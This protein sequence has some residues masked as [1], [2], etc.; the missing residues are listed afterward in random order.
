MP[1]RL[2]NDAYSAWRLCPS[3]DTVPLVGR[4]VPAITL[5]SVALPEPDGPITAVSVPGR[6]EKETRS[7]SVMPRSS[8]KLT[9]RTS[10]PPVLAAGSVR[11]TRL[12]SAK[13]KSTLPIVTTSF[14]RS[15]APLTRSPL[16]NVP[17]MLLASCIRTPC[18]FG[19][20]IAWWREASTSGTT[21]SL[22]GARPI[23]VDP[24]GAA[25]D[26][27]IQRTRIKVAAMFDTASVVRPAS[28]F[29]RASG[30]SSGRGTG[31]T[32]TFRSS[33]KRLIGPSSNVNRGPS[34]V[35]MWMVSPSRMSTECTRRCSTNIP[36]RLS[37]SI[38]T[39]RPFWQRSRTWARE[40]SGSG[41]RTS[42][43]RSLPIT[44][45]SV[46]ANVRSQ[47]PQ[48]TVIV[49]G[50]GRLIRTNLSVRRHQSPKK[51]ISQESFKASG[52]HF[53]H[54]RALRTQTLVHPEAAGRHGS[55]RGSRHFTRRVHRHRH[56]RRRRGGNHHRGGLVAPFGAVARGATG[57]RQPRRV[58]RA[59]PRRL[60]TVGL[61]A[62][63]GR[64]SG[65]GS[66]DGQGI[67]G[68]GGLPGRSGPALAF[69]AGDLG[70]GGRA[71]RHAADVRL[72]GGSRGGCEP[73]ERRAVR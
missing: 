46:A 49:G 27:P 16:R 60:P 9:P 59:R 67:G 41:T 38:A 29:I 8:V 57:R 66:G 33:R 63:R 15:T 43:C 47:P 24:G 44:T 42:A 51:Q 39:Q 65:L 13:T 70:V 32:G 40:T 28:F 23:V 72:A 48:Q 37:L 3:N 35:P 14:S 5:E 4:A 62:K 52:K 53:S 30:G 25:T 36:F 34:G 18:G 64:P 69:V 22:S 71:G 61:R 17:L 7:S 56:R 26:P 19:T 21:M 10:R 45:W 6:A 50:A 31:R 54:E 58:D 20:N 1:I 11:R 73:A 55:Y 12:P 2:R 68:L